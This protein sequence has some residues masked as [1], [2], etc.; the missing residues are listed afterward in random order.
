MLQV[1]YYNISFTDNSTNKN[2]KKGDTDVVEN[3]IQKLGPEHM[4]VPGKSRSIYME[5]DIFNQY[6]CGSHLYCAFKVKLPAQR[7]RAPMLYSSY[8][9]RTATSQ[10]KN[11][12]IKR[13][14]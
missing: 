7:W 13:Q 11:V 3:L 2:C 14:G 6:L 8:E 12:D 5:S 1:Y 4:K 9:R 10:H